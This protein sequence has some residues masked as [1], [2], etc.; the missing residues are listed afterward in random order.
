M[1]NSS[2][3]N[4]DILGNIQNNS[5]VKLIDFSKVNLKA[6]SIF[7]KENP[8]KYSTLFNYKFY[9]RIECS[10]SKLIG[11]ID[12][13]SFLVSLSLIFNSGKASVSVIYNFL[14]YYY[15]KEEAAIFITKLLI[16]FL[17]ISK[18]SV[19]TK[20]YKKL[21]EFSQSIYRNFNLKFLI[22][23]ELN[24]LDQN[25]IGR[26]EIDLFTNLRMNLLNQLD[27]S[28]LSSYF[29]I[30]YKYDKLQPI[31]N[32]IH[33][34]KPDINFL[35]SS[36][37]KSKDSGTTNSSFSTDAGSDEDFSFEQK[38]IL[39]EKALSL[40]KF[41]SNNN[42][43]ELKNKTLYYYM[44]KFILIS[45][46][47]SDN[48]LNCDLKTSALINNSNSSNSNNKD[49]SKNNTKNKYNDSANYK[50]VKEETKDK[51]IQVKETKY[52]YCEEDFYL[53]FDVNFH[54]SSSILKNKVSFPKTNAH[55]N[56]SNLL[57]NLI[58]EKSLLCLNRYIRETELN[59][60]DYKK[61]L[62]KPSKLKTLDR[63]LVLFHN[64]KSPFE[65]DTMENLVMFKSLLFYI[66]T[67]PKKLNEFIY[68]VIQNCMFS[69]T[70]SNEVIDS[71]QFLDNLKENKF[72]LFN[73][74]Y[75][76]NLL[77][78]FVFSQERI[79]LFYEEFYREIIFNEKRFNSEISYLDPWLI[80]VTSLLVNHKEKFNEFCASIEFKTL[81]SK[82]NN[83]LLYFEFPK[84]PLYKF[85]ILN[86]EI[87][88]Y[89]KHKNKISYKKK[90][91]KVEE[92]AKRLEKI[93]EINDKYKANHLSEN[94]NFY[95]RD[96]L[97]SIKVLDSQSY[98]D[99]IIVQN[100]FSNTN[101][102]K[103]KITQNFQSNQSTINFN[104]L[105]SKKNMYSYIP[106]SKKT[107]TNI[108][109]F[110][111]NQNNQIDEQNELPKNLEL[112]NH[113]KIQSIE[114]FMFLDNSFE[115]RREIMNMY[116]VNSLKKSKNNSAFAPSK[117]TGGTMVLPLNTNRHNENIEKN[118]KNKF[119]PNDKM[120]KVLTNLAN[121]DKFDN[122][123]EFDKV[124]LTSE[125]NKNANRNSDYNNL[126]NAKRAEEMNYNNSNNLNKMNN[127]NNPRYRKELI[128]SSDV[129]ADD[130]K[131]TVKNE[132]SSFEVDSNKNNIKSGNIRK[133][134]SIL[135]ITSKINEESKEKINENDS[136]YNGED[137]NDGFT[138]YNNNNEDNANKKSKKD[139]R[140][141]FNL[142]IRID[143]S[144]PLKDNNQDVVV[145]SSNRINASNILSRK[146]NTNNSN[147]GLSSPVNTLSSKINNNNNQNNNNT[148][149][150]S[151]DQN[152]SSLNKGRVLFQ[153]GSKIESMYNNNISEK[154]SNIF[155]GITNELIKRNSNNTTFKHNNHHQSY[156][157]SVINKENSN[158]EF[159]GKRR[160]RN[161]SNYI[162]NK[163][164]KLNTVPYN[165]YEKRL[166]KKDNELINKEENEEKDKTPS[167]KKVKLSTCTANQYNND[168]EIT[169][170]NHNSSA[171]KRRASHLVK[172]DSNNII[173]NMNKVVNDPDIS[174]INAEE[175]NNYCRLN[176]RYKNKDLTND[177]SNIL[178][179]KPNN[180]NNNNNNANNKMNNENNNYNA[181]NDFTINESIYKIMN[182][183]FSNQDTLIGDEFLE[184][185]NKTFKEIEYKADHNKELTPYKDHSNECPNI[186]QFILPVLKNFNYYDFC[187]PSKSRK[188]L[189]DLNI[190]KIKE[191]FLLVKE[192]IEM[193]LKN[194]DLFFL[195]S[196][197][198]NN[199]LIDFF[200]Y[201][202]FSFPIL[203]LY[204]EFLDYLAK[205]I[206][207][208]KRFDLGIPIK[209][210]PLEF[211]SKLYQGKVR[212]AFDKS[213]GE[214][215]DM[216]KI[217][218]NFKEL[219][220]NNYIVIIPIIMRQMDFS[221]SVKDVISDP[222]ITFIYLIPDGKRLRFC[223][224]GKLPSKSFFNDVI[225]SIKK[226]FADC[227]CSGTLDKK[228]LNWKAEVNNSCATYL[229]K[230][231]ESLKINPSNSNKISA[232]SLFLIETFIK[233]NDLLVNYVNSFEA[234][235][236][237]KK[238]FITLVDVLS[239]FLELINKVNTDF[240]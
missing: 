7:I 228:Y 114:Q 94:D 154:N 213:E 49:N 161:L 89:I 116:L 59:S 183:N 134:K 83:P 75:I 56:S 34:I 4:K 168:F 129:Q 102:I 60:T 66:I 38:M 132:A 208:K 165:I 86:N 125:S 178:G 160:G 22:L 100:T 115:E 193:N 194:K 157:P 210:L 133:K 192:E 201:N 120:N 122:L 232:L 21:F 169:N 221:D 142:E 218:V 138:D 239:N 44:K 167:K 121:N 68:T 91:N 10:I 171:K 187:D 123:F 112:K 203:E 31:F 32:R 107:T 139:S 47:F 227:V 200:N 35:N 146:S 54:A 205:Y 235:S 191:A 50:Y 173:S 92:Y 233:E 20:N 55:S 229:N 172:K 216:D 223:N 64:L 189:K 136:I 26:L 5:Q 58:D 143:H 170:K 90:I 13:Q 84:L 119:N 234:E 156:N 73:L 40:F 149:N 79:N 99:V 2:N 135:K 212:S 110:N 155:S 28:Y 177:I 237:S 43:I 105:I 230:I 41:I 126:I 1:N 215:A 220:E 153:T 87:H 14:S 3:K 25:N 69:S 199:N 222:V 147:K 184:I 15:D 9:E 186:D 42:K 63:N 206:N 39:K 78:N 82:L 88:A 148:A 226:H 52:K 197:V 217:Y 152:P 96:A 111:F 77:F 180:I 19:V 182:N 190:K 207:I 219:F 85:A 130:E 204:I 17:S 144:S 18:T 209:I 8:K 214:F 24:L 74:T 23:N 166:N 103:T 141:L 238:I 127:F 106:K 124:S 150:I 162:T 98:K 62:T 164:V 195:C 97:K 137:N 93:E 76:K 12:L 151:N 81:F 29:I 33:T 6:L 65:I 53:K 231:I 46:V 128:S 163:T 70:S 211:L 117:K 61:N 196:K 145:L 236:Y 188:L 16:P 48:I 179:N 175:N 109:L 108:N 104:K 159:E 11:D 158:I 113:K 118:E 185:M 27:F 95:I 224:L 51:F 225:E 36:T 37:I 240:Y 174:Y 198:S 131:E 45:L 140:D 67:I 30:F 71:K 176:L 72:S 202:Q 80:E 181:D 57:K 101:D